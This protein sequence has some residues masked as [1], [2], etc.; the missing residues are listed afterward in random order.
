MPGAEGEHGL[1][2]RSG[3]VKVIRNVVPQW[4]G[5]AAGEGKARAGGKGGRAMMRHYMAA[6]AP[7]G[8]NKTLY[9][10][11]SQHRQSAWGSAE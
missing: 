9:G 5:G 4:K 7:N 11:S 2:R 10:S 3:E 6:L 1:G 8:L